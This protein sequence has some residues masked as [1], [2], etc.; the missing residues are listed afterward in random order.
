MHREI[1]HVNEPFRS[2]SPLGLYLLTAIVGGLLAADLWPL[3]GTWLR[4][5]GVETYSWPREFFGFRYA[6]IAAVIGGARVLYSS[7]ESL[8]GGRIGSDLA[9]AIACLAAILIR[10]PLVAAEVVFIGLAG[11]CLEAFTFARTQNALGKLAE[12]FPRRCSVLRDGVE[13]RIY[14]SDLLVGDKVVVKAGGKIPVDGVVADGRSAVDTTALTGESLPADKGPGDEVLAGCIVQDGTLT[15]EARK[16]AGQTVAGQV[17]A[18]TGEALKDKAPLE[19]YADKLARYFL[20]AVLILAL[21]TFA[22]NAFIQMNSSTSP[23]SPRP[24]LRAAAN[25][26]IYPALAVLVV[27]CPCALILATPAAVIAALGRL[28]GTGV[29][30]KGGSALERL[31][32]VTAFAFDKTGTLTEGKLELGDIITFRDSSI[33]QVLTAAAMAEQW[34]EH[35]LAKAIMAEVRNRGLSVTPVDGFRQH[36]GG[37]VSATTGGT[38]ID[39]GNLR[40]MQEQNVIVPPDAIAAIE[41]LDAAG[42][43]SLLVAYAGLLLG[44]IGARDK[45]RPEAAQVLADLRAIGINPVALLTG[46]RAAVAKAVAEQL[47]VTEVHAELLPGQKASWVSHPSSFL[48]RPSDV[49]SSDP[50][51]E[52]S[53]IATGV[54]EGPRTKDQGRTVAFVGDG[55]NDA[56]ALARAGVGIAIGSGTDIAAEAGDIILMG[57]PLKPLPLL[58]RLSRETV[59]IIRQNIIVFGFAVN[60]V[61]V[62]LTGWLWPLFASSPEA[63]KQAPLAGV[64]YHQL[65]SLLVLL[66]SM[67]LLAFDRTSPTGSL[68]RA[69]D[70]AKT[71]DGWLGR[72]S[73]DEVLHELG[74]RWKPITAALAGVGLIG[75]LSTC[76]ASVAIGEVGIA[77]RF[78]KAV[79]DLEPGLHIRWP[80]PV[81]MV[82]RLRPGDVRT[83]EVGFRSLTEEQ[84]QRKAGP[85]DKKSSAGAVS[86]NTW[87]SGHSDGI[88]RLSDEAVMVTGD[89]D[90]V[91]I[92]ATVRYH[93]SD[94]RKF[95]F[96]VR[97]PDGLVRSTAE[98]VLRELVAGQRF[99]ELLTVKRAELEQD[100]LERL[101]RRLA[102]AAP[103]GIGVSLDGLT[104]HDLHPP[105]EVVNSYH[106][107]AKAIQERDRVI[108]EAEADALRLKRRSQEEADRIL[109]RSEAEAHTLRQAAIADRDAFLAWHAI[110]SR[111]APDEELLLA[112]ERDRRVKSGE[113]Q[114]T[115]D[116]DLADRRGRVLTE[117]RFLIENRLVIQAV[118]DVLRMRDKILIDA[119]D[120]PGRRHLFLVDPDLLRMPSLVAPRQ[121]KEP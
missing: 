49:D 47:P 20:P 31:A 18:L 65:G 75:W 13:V 79:A 50:V 6:L 25:V 54:P 3:V 29:L 81:E 39:V 63:Y 26:A 72:L 14:T 71:V 5:Q 55:I 102:G 85:S 27:A 68:A 7:L 64:L 78:G 28:A 2:E 56:P 42:Q 19:R 34:S 21:V 83:V 44:A 110:R 16:V 88:A 100:A 92:L 117:R 4:S 96:G 90:L 48:L 61:G 84:L 35:P 24:T 111:L 36:P 95:L 113:S 58:V 82:T 73:V 97:E 69:R 89:G 46:D 103:G 115:V 74:D 41:R 80:W 52:V 8:F 120:L 30:I 94:P 17:I 107:V 106:A 10:E 32:G 108:N 77:Q 37:G 98:S 86:G 99:Q 15:V 114:V 12:L 93:V 67:R 1:S 76:F 116:K 91:E 87:A 53:G 23:E 51:P 22:G 11:E 105:P 60:L 118:V 45:I 66:N 70:V 59:R 62:V 119:A 33:E 112:T 43:T 109:K 104:L 101:R 9:L 121:D 57:E 38:M 40:L